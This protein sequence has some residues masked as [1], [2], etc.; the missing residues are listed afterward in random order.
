[1]ASRPNEVER[2]DVYKLLQSTLIASKGGVPIEKLNRKN[3]AKIS[4]IDR[5]F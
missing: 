5:S 2:A 3:F 4:F 1:M